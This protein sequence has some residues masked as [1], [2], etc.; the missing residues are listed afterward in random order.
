MAV[1]Y[2]RADG[3][4][5][6]SNV[7]TSF[8]AAWATPEYANT[9]ATNYDTIYLCS[10]S[11]NKF[12]IATELTN[13]AIFWRG[14]DLVDGSPY[15]GAGKA[16]MK[17]T[18]TRMFNDS[19]FYGIH[20]IDF[21]GSSTTT[22]FCGSG[23][24]SNGTFTGCNFHDFERA[25]NLGN[26]VN[27]ICYRCNFYG[28]SDYGMLFYGETNASMVFEQCAF[29]NNANNVY[30]ATDS[31][32][33]SRRKFTFRNCRIFN[34]TSNWNI[35]MDYGRLALI[36]NVIYGAPSDNIT[37]K[38]DAIIDIAINNIISGAGAYGIDRSETSTWE[39]VYMD[40][41]CFY[42]NTSGNVNSGFN[43]GVLP[44]NNNILTD[45]K[46]TSVVSGSEDFSLQATSPCLDIGYGY[47][48]GK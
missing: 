19:V 7:G 42:G 5:S 11:S 2:V 18:S 27:V 4:G 36:G 33:W 1:Y 44:G 10:N 41:N 39:Y 9:T 20:D 40:Y 45:P 46:F 8:G 22:R 25:L 48:G 30:I 6:D 38:G 32:N 47:R 21:E 15:N 37:F 14:A 24:I 35:Y 17:A 28:N 16:Y 26:A 12:T 31:A 34:P 29:Y 13:G 3:G 23:T 43:G